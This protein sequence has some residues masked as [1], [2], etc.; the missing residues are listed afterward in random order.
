MAEQLTHPSP[1]E[2]SAFSLGQLPNEQAASV[3]SHVSQ[4][5]RCCETLLNLASDDTFVG[6]LQ[7]AKRTLEDQTIGLDGGDSHPS[8]ISGVPA[9]LAEHPR[10]EI[11][12]LIGK[13]GMGDVF[14]ARHRMMERTVALKVI[15]RELVRRPEA[16][17]RFHREVKTAARLSHP[18]IVTAHECR[19]CWRFALLGDGVRRWRESR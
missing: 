13:G 5:E 18:N 3:E 9:Q 12:G 1:N 11:I 19:S 17:G 10:Y 14:K 6:L 2:L 4:C 15:N 7:E 8:L 16:V